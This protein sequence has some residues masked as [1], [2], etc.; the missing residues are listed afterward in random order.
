[1]THGDTPRA[2]PATLPG[3]RA[4]RVSGPHFAPVAPITPQ[5]GAS[6]LRGFALPMLGAFAAALAL[7]GSLAA[8]TV[9]WGDSA[10][11]QTV[12]LRGGILHP[13]GYPIFVL[14]GRLFAL[15]PFPDPAYRINFMSAFFA[16][17]T[18]ALAVRMAAEARLSRAAAIAATLVLAASYTFWH[19]AL[20]AEVYSLAVFL[21]ALALWRTLAAARSGSLPGILIAGLLSGLT[22]TGHLMMVPTIACL[23]L[24]LALQVIRGRVPARSIPVLAALLAVFAVGLSPYF[25][26]VWADARDVPFNYLR[27]V[28]QVQMPDGRTADF[29]T[30]WERVHWLVTSR[31]LYPPIPQTYSLGGTARGLVYSLAVLFLFELGPFA[32]LFVLWGFVRLLRSHLRAALVLAAVGAAVLLF[33]AVIAAGTHVGIFLLPCTLVCALFIGAAVAPLIARRPVVGILAIVAIV[34]VPHAIRM[35]AHDHPIGPWRLRVQQEDP[36]LEVGWLPSLRGF[37]EP[38]RYGEAV[39]DAIPRD[40]FVLAEWAEFANLTYFRVVEGRRPDLTLQTLSEARLVERMQRWQEGRAVE[41]TP[42]VFLSRPPAIAS[43][44]APLDSV[45]LA[46]G[47]RYWIR[48]APVGVAPGSAGGP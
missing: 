24:A 7:Y 27:L 29:D 21:G 46:T 32:P 15:L 48:R 23:G 34:A 18:V 42:F 17:G 30:P 19:V 35:H 41:R 20:H 45:V 5:P 33:T 40:A 4:Q 28:E 8:P 39:L 9:L 12:A 6:G 3:E 47:R 14:V 44:G 16:A 13:S 25:Y 2:A 10:E 22:L 1:M 36:S 37:H 11:F 43:A 38:R 31:G 26:L